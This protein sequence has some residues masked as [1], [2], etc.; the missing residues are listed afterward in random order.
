MAILNTEDLPKQS[1]RTI[2]KGTY[3]FSVSKFEEKTDKNNNVFLNLQAELMGN[4]DESK[5]LIFDRFYLVHATS[6]PAVDIG[7]A[8][9]RA[10]LESCGFRGPFDTENDPQKFI[11]TEFLVDVKMD[12]DMNGEPQSKFAKFHEKAP[13]KQALQRAQPLPTVEGRKQAVADVAAILP[14]PTIDNI[15]F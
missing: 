8:R 5:F 3:T 14:S 9:L 12:K 7:K 1:N 6:K 11:D 15:P 2:P 4:P 13:A 10:F